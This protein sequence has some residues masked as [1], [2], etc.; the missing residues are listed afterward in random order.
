MVDSRKLRVELGKLHNME[1]VLRSYSPCG[2]VVQT[3]SDNVSSIIQFSTLKQET[4]VKMQNSL[5][6]FIVTLRL[7]GHESN[8]L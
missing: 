1:Q 6:S 7:F 8:L 5:S 2:F 3:V 4:M